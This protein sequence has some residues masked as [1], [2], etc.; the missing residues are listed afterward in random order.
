MKFNSKWVIFFPVALFAL[1]APQPAQATQTGL[2]VRGYS[3]TEIPPLKSDTAY[4]MC[5]TSI[6]PFINGTWDWQPYEQCDSDW[7]M[8][9]YTGYLQ[10]P[11]HQTIEFW[12]ASDDGGTIK[13]GTEE[14]GVWQDQGCSATE[15]GLIDMAA[16]TQAIDAWM[17]ENGGGTCFMFAWNIDGAGWEIVQPEFFTADAL[18]T[19]S[20]TTTEPSTTTTEM[21]PSTTTTSPSTTLPETT[22]S[23]TQMA[24]STTSVQTTS[25]TT[26]AQ[27]T[28]TVAPTVEEPTTTTT[29]TTLLQEPVTTDNV[30]D[31]EPPAEITPETVVPVL[32]VLPQ[33]EPQT[34]VIDEPQVDASAVTVEEGTVVSV[35]QFAAIVEQLDNA[36]EEEVVAIVEELLQADLSNEQVAELVTDVHVLTSITGEQAAQVF[37]Q[38]EET[39]LSE[40][41]AEVIAAT[42][43]SPD[44]PEE[45][46]EAFEEQIDI[47]GNDGFSEYVPIGSNVSVA[48]RRTIIVGTTILVAMPSPAVRRT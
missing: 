44:V 32:D 38:V 27:P 22:T 21:P 10:I 35:E 24:T 48:V 14:F 31:V 29:S 42:L 40:A 6:E 15:T 1:F 11:E 16:G 30:A 36:S 19:P 34:T 37:A 26:P 45:V 47:F 3:I 12:I 46:K 39:Q 25:T 43:N 2:L 23:S 5:G 28:P 41:M 18:P 9:H 13:I 17:Y 4:E 20:T 8:L 33:E 7:F